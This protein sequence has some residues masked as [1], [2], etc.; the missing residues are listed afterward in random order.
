VAFQPIA[1]Q[2]NF[3]QLLDEASGAQVVLIPQQ[4]R[5]R[6]KFELFLYA[7]TIY[8]K[9]RSVRAPIASLFKR[10]RLKKHRYV[11]LFAKSM[12]DETEEFML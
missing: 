5:F 8:S 3:Q 9:D 12:F 10:Q 4:I 6:T 2:I 11:D 1:F 7:L